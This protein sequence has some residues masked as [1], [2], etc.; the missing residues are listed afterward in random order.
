M[1]SNHEKAIKFGK[2]MQ[3]RVEQGMI[4]HKTARLI[5]HDFG[6]SYAKQPQLQDRMGY[7]AKRE[8][9]S[10]GEIA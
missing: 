4:T 7:W 5:C 1:S 10:K 6:Y 9:K 3:H 2:Q 8:L